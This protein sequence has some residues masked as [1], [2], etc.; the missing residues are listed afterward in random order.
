L[1]WGETFFFGELKCNVKAVNIVRLLIAI[2]ASTLDVLE[3]NSTLFSI[4][5]QFIVALHYMSSLISV[6]TLDW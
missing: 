1:E 5:L 3:G 6:E 2:A 4:D